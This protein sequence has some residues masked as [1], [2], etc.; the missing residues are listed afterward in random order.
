MF[1]PAAWDWYPALACGGR[2][3]QVVLEARRF[4]C[5]NPACPVARFAGHVPGLTGW[6]QRRTAG[7]QGLLEKVA[8]VLAAALAIRMRLC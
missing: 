7:L 5:G 8:L 2:P 4:R 1:R 6:Y 3:V